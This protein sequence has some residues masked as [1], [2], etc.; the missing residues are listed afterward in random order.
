LIPNAT[1]AMLRAVAV[2][3]D[4]DER[5]RA[6]AFSYLDGLLA[7]GEH[8]SRIDLQSFTYD[9]ARLPLI[10]PQTGIWKPAGFRAA[11]SILT[12][13]VRPGEVPPYEDNVGDDG[14]PR[15]KWRGTDPRHS[16]NRALR[17]AMA[18]RK[19]LMWF[20]GVAPGIYRAEYPVWLVA[21]EPEAMQFVVALEESVRVGWSPELILQPFNPVRR[22]AETIVRTRLHQRPFRDRV[23][24]AYGSQ[25]ALCRLRH[26]PLLDAA[27]IKEDSEG[28]EPIVPNGV[29]MCAIHHRAFDAYVL[30]VRP[31]YTVEVRPDVLAEHDGPTLQHALQSLHGELIQLPRHR[32]ERPDRDLLEERYER[33]RAAG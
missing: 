22:Y 23:L 20:L 4:V 16:D 30:A 27:H 31:D 32:A 6:S 12:T 19:P 11:L 1:G 13:Y 33:F 28:G 25:C 10:S 24:L 15:Y 14:Y 5:V 9:G 17:T 8:V 29:A 26:P 2:T 3:G 18:L 7:S 21:E